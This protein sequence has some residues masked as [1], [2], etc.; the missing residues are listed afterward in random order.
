MTHCQHLSNVE[1]HFASTEG[2]FWLRMQIEQAKKKNCCNWLCIV[3]QREYI[4]AY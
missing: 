2:F 1:M 3:E 4:I